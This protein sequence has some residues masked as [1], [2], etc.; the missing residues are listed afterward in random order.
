MTEKECGHPLIKLELEEIFYIGFPSWAFEKFEVGHLTGM[1]DMG[2]MLVSTV[3][4]SMYM[5]LNRGFN[6][7]EECA[8]DTKECK[9]PFDRLLRNDLNRIIILFDD[10]CGFIID[11]LSDNKIV[12]SSILKDGNLLIWVGVNEEEF[13]NI[14]AKYEP[15]PIK[16]TSRKKRLKRPMKYPTN[17]AIVTQGATVLVVPIDGVKKFVY[18]KDSRTAKMLVIDKE[19]N[20]WGEDG[21]ILDYDPSDKLDESPF[22]LLYYHNDIAGIYLEDK[23]HE[24]PINVV[25]DGGDWG[26]YANYLNGLENTAI[27]DNGDLLIAFSDELGEDEVDKQFDELVKKLNDEIKE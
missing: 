14:I 10:Q 23:T 11:P 5:I 9:T 25:W 2:R 21:T 8:W 27:L 26:Y 16:K 22:E 3:S 7:Y 19:Y 1:M 12:K 4:K 13:N 17:I 20:K 15:T 18:D 24:Y 6:S